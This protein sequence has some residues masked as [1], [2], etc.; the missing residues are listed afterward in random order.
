MII[1]NIELL[2]KNAEK[3]KT[4]TSSIKILIESFSILKFNKKNW[5]RKVVFILVEIVIAYFIV[6]QPTTI[7][8]MQEIIK[9][10]LAVVI[11]LLAIVFT[12]YALFQA[13]INNTMLIA[14]LSVE[15][16]NEANLYMTNK[17]F[18]NVMTFELFCALTN[19]IVFIALIIIAEAHW[20]INIKVFKEIFSIIVISSIL[21]I[22][23]EGIWEIKSFV[24][25]VFQLFNLHAYSRLVEMIKQEKKK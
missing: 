15:D 1:I 19:L 25:N 3:L 5:I 12:G 7:L 18:A 13:L 21:W 23:F 14:M 22:N 16:E 8:L 20:M 4:K 10:I 24:Y 9:E 6:L 2:L 11:A 17:Y